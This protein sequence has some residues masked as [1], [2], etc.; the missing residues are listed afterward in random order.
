MP[1][2]VAVQER[3]GAVSFHKPHLF[4]CWGP[5]D[6]VRCSDKQYEHKGKCCNRCQ[7]GTET[8]SPSRAPEAQLCQSQRHGHGQSQPRLLRVSPP[9]QQCPQAHLPLSPS[10]GAAGDLVGALRPPAPHQVCRGSLAQ[11]ELLQPQDPMAQAACRDSCSRWH[12]QIGSQSLA[13]WRQ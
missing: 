13:C 3:G 6:A 7:P 11:S 5:G 1:A 10:A 9:C 4:Q 8:P 2:A 12:G